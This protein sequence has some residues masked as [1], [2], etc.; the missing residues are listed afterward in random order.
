MTNFDLTQVFEW[1]TLQISE[2][3]S[4]VLPVLGVLLFVGLLLVLVKETA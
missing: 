1:A 4:D 2:R 3:F